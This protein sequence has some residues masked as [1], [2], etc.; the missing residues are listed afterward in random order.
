MNTDSTLINKYT[1]QELSEMYR[2]NRFSN[3][4]FKYDYKA[5]DYFPKLYKEVYSQLF[6]T[7]GDI[8][9]GLRTA[10]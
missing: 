9:G 5:G 3:P 8:A 6:V 2:F 7:I 4:I 1:T 10:N